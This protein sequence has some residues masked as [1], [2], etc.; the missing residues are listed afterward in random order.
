[1]APLKFTDNCKEFLRLADDLVGHDVPP[2]ETSRLMEHARACARCTKEWRAALERAAALQMLTPWALEA[3][4]VHPPAVG[5]TADA[6]FARLNAGEGIP[7]WSQRWVRPISYAAAAL[8]VVGA[9]IYSSIYFMNNREGLSSSARESLVNANVSPQGANLQIT[10]DPSL[11]SEERVVNPFERKMLLESSLP[12]NGRKN[13]GVPVLVNYPW[14]IFEK[15]NGGG[16]GGSV[17][18]PVGG[19]TYNQSRVH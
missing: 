17:V 10:D 5:E 8:L 7:S 16:G 2:E 3:G 15:A 13:G 12:I 14:S 18:T 9:G 4:G 19:R 11:E 1:M 6:V